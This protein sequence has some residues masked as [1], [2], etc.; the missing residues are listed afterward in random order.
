MPLFSCISMQIK[1]KPCNNN[2]NV[3]K[4]T[5]VR[6]RMEKARDNAKSSVDD[7]SDNENNQNVSIEELKQKILGR[8]IWKILFP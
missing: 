1:S 5:S 8:S 2:K 4:R 7:D 6:E 3:S